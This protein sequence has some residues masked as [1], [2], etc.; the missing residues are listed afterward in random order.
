M[1][2]ELSKAR[3]TYEK[4]KELNDRLQRGIFVGRVMNLTIFQLENNYLIH[5]RK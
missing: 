1:D 3:Q 2:V 5:I 4:I